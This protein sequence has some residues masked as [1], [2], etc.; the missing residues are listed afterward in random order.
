MKNSCLFT[1]LFQCTKRCAGK[2]PLYGGKYNT[3]LLTEKFDW[4]KKLCP[5]TALNSVHR[6]QLCIAQK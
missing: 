2:I 1:E 5:I 3:G 4:I 6:R